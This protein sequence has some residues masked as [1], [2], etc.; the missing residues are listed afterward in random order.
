MNSLQLSN[1]VFKI[2]AVGN[3]SKRKEAF[4]AFSLE[5]VN[6]Y[7]RNGIATGLC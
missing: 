3:E 7:V 2:L 1:F 6:C 4:A 5:K